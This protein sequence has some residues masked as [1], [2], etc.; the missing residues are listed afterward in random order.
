MSLF[1]ELAESRATPMN[2]TGR[3]YGVATAVVTDN[4]DP[5][6]LGRVKLRFDWLGDDVESDWA[7]IATMMAGGERGSF[8]LPEVDD[9]VLVAFEHGDP[10]YPFVLGA[11]WNGKDKPPE[12]N[13]DGKNNKRVI[14]SRS[15]HIIRFDDTSGSEKVEIID[16]SGKNSLVID[17]SADT[18]TIKS[19]KDIVFEAPSGKISLSAQDVEIKASG[20]GKVETQSGLD[21]KASGTLT[22][23]GATVNIN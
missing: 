6:G 14:K 7:P 8:F 17:A 9:E 1:T 2:S 18:I 22:I 20:S 5:D 21:L 4:K 12:S 15:G 16:K 23:K 3:I 11:L 19:N 13:S 10:R